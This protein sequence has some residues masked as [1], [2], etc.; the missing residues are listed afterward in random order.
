MQRL[1]T[2]SSNPGKADMT[3]GGYDECQKALVSLVV[4]TLKPWTWML[5]QSK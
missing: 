2:T 3:M 1:S 4:A 5:E